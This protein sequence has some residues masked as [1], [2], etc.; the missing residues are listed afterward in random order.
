M[1]EEVAETTTTADMTEKRLD[2]MLQDLHA[3][4]LDKADKEDGMSLILFETEES[5]T[6]VID[7]V[8]DLNSGR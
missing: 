3:L 6:N 4:K 5:L 8:F 2:E 7:S 1:K